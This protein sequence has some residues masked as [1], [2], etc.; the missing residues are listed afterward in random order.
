MELKVSVDGHQ[1]VVC[2]IN[3]KT[4]VQEVVIALAQATGR[5]GRY[6]LVEKWRNSERLLP[7]SEC[8]LAILEKWGQY[9][10]DVE[11][12]LR[13]SDSKPS[14]MRRDDPQSQSSSQLQ[15]GGHILPRNNSTLGLAQQ[16]TRIQSSPNTIGKNGLVKHQQ[17][18]NW[19][20]QQIEAHTRSEYKKVLFSQENSLSEMEKQIQ[21]FDSEIRKLNNQI[22]ATQSLQHTLNSKNLP[23]NFAPLSKNAVKSQET[24]N[25]EQSIRENDKFLSKTVE[26]SNHPSTATDLIHSTTKQISNSNQDVDK[27][28]N[29]CIILLAKLNSTTGLKL[30]PSINLLRKLKSN[31]SNSQL[32]F[33]KNLYEITKKD[34]N[35]NKKTEE[36]DDIS[37]QV[38]EAG[39]NLFIEKTKNQLH[40]HVP[41]IRTLQPMENTGRTVGRGFMDMA[42]GSTLQ[43]NHSGNQPTFMKGMRQSPDN[44]ETASVAVA[45]GQKNIFKNLKK[46]KPEDT[47]TNIEGVWV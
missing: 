21:Q 8:P 47:D 38:R 45:V 23:L 20:E 31:F 28:S 40:P 18:V 3:E 4:N 29:Q 10:N 16:N 2:G 32:E 33:E 46:S 39:L 37:R 12:I 34:A 5:V 43:R 22:Q 30:Q 44:L 13:R 25:L 7:P 41:Q 15:R 19:M 14:E 24:L 27:L 1:R 42:L 36:L 17:Q 6:T 11:F 9:S 35:I 26:S